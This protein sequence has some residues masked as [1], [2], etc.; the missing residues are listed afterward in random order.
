MTGRELS[1]LYQL[2]HNKMRDVDGFL[3]QEAFD[4]LLKFIFYKENV[5]DLQTRESPILGQDGLYRPSLP[6]STEEIRR[7]FSSALYDKADWAIGLWNDGSMHISDES[8]VYLDKLFANV[9][10][11]ELAIDIRSTALRTFITPDIRRSLGIYLTPEDV[12]CMMVELLAPKKDEKTLDPACG[13]GTFLM[14]ALKYMH[15]AETNKVDASVYGIDKNPRMLMLADLNLGNLKGTRFLRA[16]ADSLRVLSSNDSSPLLGLRPN[17]VDVILTNP[18]FGVTVT[19]D[20][21]ILPLFDIGSTLSQQD[22]QGMPS[23]VLFLELC[24]RLLRPEGRLGIILPRSVLTNDRIHPMRQSLDNL[25]YLTHMVDLPH[26][27]FAAAGT[28][29]TTVAA[30]FRKHPERNR[31]KFVTVKVCNITNV[32]YDTTG[33]YSEGNQLTDLARRLSSQTVDNDNPQIFVHKDVVGA[34]SLQR[35]AQLL[36]ERHTSKCGV[37]LRPF[38]TYS[39]TGRTPAR[40]A[41]MDDGMFILKVGNLTGRGIDWEARD[42][43]FVSSKEAT[44]RARKGALLLEEGDILLTSSAHAPK[45]IAKKVDIVHRIPDSYKDIGLT[46]VGELIKVRAKQDVDPY[47]LLAALR[48]PMVRNS[49]Q[50]LIRGQTAHLKPDDLLSVGVPCDLLDPM[51]ELIEVADMLR[52]EADLAFELSVLALEVTSRLSAIPLAPD[53]APV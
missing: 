38:V 20:T 49:L 6:M 22:K 34:S 13:S 3:P 47:V 4:E 33:R 12:V 50:A 41:Y 29:T 18:P 36:S 43:N 35:S 7:S 10:F 8:L 25:G 26:E 39:G 15:Y 30:F 9:L 32:G 42:R 21:G 19:K 16:C 46:F 48:H 44:K 40:S 45:Y 31:D 23:E 2:A 11:S 1:K 37:Q 28:Q 17:S 53:T 14:E 5:E 24:L 51:P 27:T 52:R